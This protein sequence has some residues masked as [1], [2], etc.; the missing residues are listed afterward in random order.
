MPKDKITKVTIINILVFILPGF[1]WV[2]AVEGVGLEVW[3]YFCRWANLRSNLNE[4][5]YP[6]F[7]CL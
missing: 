5:F 6:V 1:F 4:F 3:A 2:E 7:I